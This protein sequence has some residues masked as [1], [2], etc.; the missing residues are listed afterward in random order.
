MGRSRGGRFFHLDSDFLILVEI[1]IMSRD[2]AKKLKQITQHYKFNVR[3]AYLEVDSQP[4]GAP[5]AFVIITMTWQFVH[6][7]ESSKNTQY[8]HR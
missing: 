8:R 4:Y 5:H 3:L 1:I 2:G 7:S 6:K